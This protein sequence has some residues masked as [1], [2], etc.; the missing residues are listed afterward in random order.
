MFPVFCSGSTG[1]GGRAGWQTVWPWWR[2]NE[3]L[4]YISAYWGERKRLWYPSG[5]E[6]VSPWGSK[7]AQVGKAFC[8]LLTDPL[9]SL[10][11][12]TFQSPCFGHRRVPEQNAAVTFINIGRMERKAIAVKTLA[13]VPLGQE[14]TFWRLVWAGA[15]CTPF[16]VNI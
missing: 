3:V 2:I 16:V 1:E 10:E 14:K 4:A 15:I 12:L 13:L 9:M 6:L 7:P 5:F 8:H 11:R